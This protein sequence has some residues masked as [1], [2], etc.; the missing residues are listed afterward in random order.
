MR[1]YQLLVSLVAKKRMVNQKSNYKNGDIVLRNYIT[2]S[3]YEFSIQFFALFYPLFPYWFSSLVPRCL[4]SWPPSWAERIARISYD[5]ILPS[6]KLFNLFS[7]LNILIAVF[8]SHFRIIRWSCNFLPVSRPDLCLS[9]RKTHLSP[10]KLTLSTAF[11][12]NGVRFF[13]LEILIRNLLMFVCFESVFGPILLSIDFFCTG[14]TDSQ[15][16]DKNYIIIDSLGVIKAV[17]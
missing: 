7:F 3:C 13:F 16:H 4:F 14:L 8:I 17:S 5:D 12:C 1:G 11:R 15:S 10:R 9:M 2:S 6:E